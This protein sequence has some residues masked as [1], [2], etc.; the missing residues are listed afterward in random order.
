MP[1]RSNLSFIVVSVCMV[2]V[3]VCILFINLLDR[4]ALRL[5]GPEGA[6]SDRGW[7]LILWCAVPKT[8]GLPWTFSKHKLQQNNS[9]KIHITNPIAVLLFVAVLFRHSAWLLCRF[10]R[11][12]QPDKAGEPKNDPEI[13]KT[14]N[15]KA[16]DRSPSTSYPVEL[17]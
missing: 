12:V 3:R 17:K 11:L 2:M 16:Y 13:T 8:D 7:L 4:R 5:R 14:Q 9:R 10:S 1:F 15:N 6:A